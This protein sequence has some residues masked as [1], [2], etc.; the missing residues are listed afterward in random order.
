LIIHTPVPQRRRSRGRYR[1]VVLESISFDSALMLA[2]EPAVV[3]C[4]K[5]AFRE[6]TKSQIFH[7]AVEYS[8]QS[9]PFRLVFHCSNGVLMVPEATRPSI[10][11]LGLYMLRA[12]YSRCLQALPCEPQ[13]CFFS[14]PIHSRQRE[15]YRRALASAFELQLPGTAISMEQLLPVQLVHASDTNA[16][17]LRVISDCICLSCL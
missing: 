9:G 8:F 12:V 5:R 6:E 3:S 10:T 14:S 16:P 2:Q 17:R 13:Q 7:G 11:A 15:R 4:T 1:L